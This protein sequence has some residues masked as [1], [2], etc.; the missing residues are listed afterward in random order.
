MQV[1]LTV[2]MYVIHSLLWFKISVQLVKFLSAE[3]EIVTKKY[4]KVE[5]FQYLLKTRVRD[6]LKAGRAG[7]TL[8]ILELYCTS[9]YR[10]YY[11]LN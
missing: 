5:L 7:V 11:R 10:L 8:G 4:L 6:I 3:P 9:L 2:S 1:T